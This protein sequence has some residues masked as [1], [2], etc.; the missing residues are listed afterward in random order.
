MEEYEDYEDQEPTTKQK[1][2]KF[3]KNGQGQASLSQGIGSGRLDQ[4]S[5]KKG[6]WNYKNEMQIWGVSPGDPERSTIEKEK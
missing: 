3:Q 1:V 4:S 2:S 5:N 6:A